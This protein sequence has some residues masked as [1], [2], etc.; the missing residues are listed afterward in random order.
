[1]AE[2]TRRVERLESGFSNSALRTPY[3]LAWLECEHATSVDGDDP[4]IGSRIRCEPCERERAGSAELRAAIEA[5]TFSHARFRFGL[6][7]VYHRDVDSPS[8][9]TLA[10]CGRE[11][12][13]EPLLREAGRPGAISPTEPR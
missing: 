10:A 6:V 2:I 9:V 11:Q 12:I 5:E 7:H 3:R 13:V 1:M 4:E 8:G